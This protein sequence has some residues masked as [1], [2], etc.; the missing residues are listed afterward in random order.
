MPTIIGSLKGPSGS[1]GSTGSTGPAGT[2]GANGTNGTNGTAFLSGS[3]VPAAGLGN[4]GD[5]YLD[6]STGDLY[7]KTA[8]VW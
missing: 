7:K 5:T 1:T 4:N 8:G 6:V 2:N 3:G